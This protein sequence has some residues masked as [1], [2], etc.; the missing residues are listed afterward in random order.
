MMT[1]SQSP[2]N[3][4]CHSKTHLILKKKIQIKNLNIAINRQVIKTFQFMRIGFDMTHFFLV[5][6]EH[7][8]FSLKLQTAITVYNLPSVDFM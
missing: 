2:Q 3:F 6:S 4:H 1:Q 8:K 5:I 7:I